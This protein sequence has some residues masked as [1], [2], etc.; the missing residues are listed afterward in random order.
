MTGLKKMWCVLILVLALGLVTGCELGTSPD[1]NGGEQTPE[2]VIVYAY[3][4]DD[5]GGGLFG[6]LSPTMTMNEWCLKVMYP[7]RTYD[8]L[9]QGG[10]VIY[11]DEN[12]KTPFTGSDILNENTVVYCEDTLN[13][14]GEKTGGITGTITL[15]DI[16]DPATTKVFIN[17]TS[18]NGYPG[19]WWNIYRKID[20]SGVTGTSAT[21]NWSLPVYE[22]FKPPSQAAF[23]LIVLPGDSLNAYTVS[24]PTPK[25]ISDVNANVGDLGTVS[26]RGVTLSGTINVTYNG[27]PVPH[28]EIYANYP[29]QG[30][31]NITYLSSPEPDAPWSVT[32]GID[33]NPNKEI[34]FK[35]YGCSKKN[36]GIDDI[37]F[38]R[39]LA[40]PVVQVV[41]NQSVSGIVLDM[42]DITSMR[43]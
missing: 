15:N 22:S 29:V 38:D 3:N 20:M 28:V 24:V 23:S 34:E 10:I 5:L 18:F 39:T 11:K 9:V 33:A 21:L 1:D 4:I 36:W 41:N 17:S 27:Q 8:M 25:T 7:P 40:D 35:V 31:L 43:P 6:S 42:G 26:V 13:G 19:N 16:S 30:T 14:Q 12:L 37:L 32:F 2:T